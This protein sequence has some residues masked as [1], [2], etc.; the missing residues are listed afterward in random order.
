MS[1]SYLFGLYFSSFSFSG[2][3]RL[4]NVFLSLCWTT[5]STGVRNLSVLPLRRSL[6]KRTNSVAVPRK[7]AWGLPFISPSFH[8]NIKRI[9]EKLWGTRWIV[10]ESER[11]I[12]RSLHYFLP[13]AHC[14]YQR[15]RV[16][17][18]GIH[19]ER[20]AFFYFFNIEVDIWGDDFVD[21]PRLRL[22]NLIRTFTEDGGAE[23]L[24][25]S[26]LI[27]SGCYF[28]IIVM[29]LGVI[30]SNGD[31]W[32]EQRRTAISILRDFGMGKNLMEELVILCLIDPVRSH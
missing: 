26:K 27:W 15:L 20:F 19:W 3:L 1:L 10:R 16:D 25:C 32:R 4:R 17:S 14:S 24:I 21:R 2:N 6:S 23:S 18:R 12:R 9:S 29:H 5:F 30:N 8:S 11:G 7:F 28:D 13:F 22:L 31:I